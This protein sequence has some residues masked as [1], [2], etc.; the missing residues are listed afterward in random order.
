MRFGSFAFCRIRVRLLQLCDF[1]LSG[2]FSVCVVGGVLLQLGLIRRQ[3]NLQL[4][5]LRAD[6]VGVDGTRRWRFTRGALKGVG[7]ASKKNRKPGRCAIPNPHH[8]RPRAN[9]RGAPTC[10]RLGSGES[11]L[12]KRC[13]TNS[14]FDTWVGGLPVGA[15]IR[16]SSALSISGSCS[17]FADG[18]SSRTWSRVV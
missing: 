10:S 15:R 13:F 3:I 4:C 18:A 6:V 9:P 8:A 2:R 11:D 16:Q 7:Q 5:S 17:S 12:G 14:S 1:A